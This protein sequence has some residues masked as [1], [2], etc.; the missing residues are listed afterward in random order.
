MTALVTISAHEL[1]LLQLI[2]AHHMLVQCCLRLETNKE[3]VPLLVASA[4]I[5]DEFVDEYD[6][7]RRCW[8]RGCRT[9]YYGCE[10]SVVGSHYRVHIQLTST[11]QLIDGFVPIFLL[12]N[13]TLLFILLL[14]WRGLWHCSMTRPSR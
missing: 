1:R 14:Q 9:R 5:A 13:S 7:S 11:T 12:P 3:T 2:S 4:L 6:H 8:Y 10:V